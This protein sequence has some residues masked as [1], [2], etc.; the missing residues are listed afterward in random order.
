MGNIIDVSAL[1]RLLGRHGHHPSAARRHRSTLATSHSFDGESTPWRWEPQA[2]SGD[3]IAG[4]VFPERSMRV[5]RD[6]GEEQTVHLGEVVFLHPYRGVAVDAA[7]AGAGVCLW[8]PWDSLHEV[9]AGVHSPGHV[10]SST[11]LV[12]GLR[13]FLTSLLTQPAEPTPYTDYLVER[14]LV[15]MSFG[16]LLESVPASIAEAR[17]ERPIDRARSL[18]LMRRGEVDFGVAALAAEMHM[19][20]RHL[21]RLFAAEKSSPA[22]ELRGMRVHLANELF[23]DPAYHALSLGEIA[24][25][26]G[27]ANATALRRA[28]AGRGLP[29][30]SALRPRA[31]AQ[32][33]IV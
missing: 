7:G 18:M 2:L 4:L 25:H 33:S 21:Q 30:P 12:A 32:A 11:P 24:E 15:E 9:E 16:V 19:S 10:L 22:A 20:V 8:L 31:R 23:G 26:A 5:V 3:A 28:F 6:D 17:D 27:F 14:V 1:V 29:V 13:A